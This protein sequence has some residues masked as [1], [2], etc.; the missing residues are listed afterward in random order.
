MRPVVKDEWREV[1]FPPICSRTPTAWAAV[2]TSAMGVPE[3]DRLTAGVSDPGGAAAD[4]E[5]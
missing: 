2:S 4:A 3:G 1:S 5:E